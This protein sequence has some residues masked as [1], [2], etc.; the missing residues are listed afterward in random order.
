MGTNYLTF[1]GH[2]SLEFGLS[3]SGSGTYN[4]PERAV[5]TV[6]I[7]GRSGALLLD[8]G[9]FQN[10]TVTYPVSLTARFPQRAHALKGW[11]LGTAGYQRLEDTYD[12]DHFRL[13]RFAGPLEWEVGFRQWS[14]SASLAFDCKPQRFRKDGERPVPLL[15]GQSLFNGQPF[16]ALPLIRV[17]GQGPGTLYIGGY[18][19]E[20]LDLEGELFLDSDAQDAYQGTLNKNNTIAADAFPALEP[21]D[22]LVNWGG[23]IQAVEITPRWWTI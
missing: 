9:R 16:P 2:S 5:E 11:L 18:V 3:I 17:A 21:G 1:A 12:P 15:Q 20:I 7:P 4:A 22:N 19:V 23:G 8:N 14:G 6:E 10:I 13:A